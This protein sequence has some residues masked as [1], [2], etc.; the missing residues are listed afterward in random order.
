MRRKTPLNV[1]PGWSH[2]LPMP[3]PGV[4]VSVTLDDAIGQ[5]SRLPTPPRVFFWTELEHRCPEG[6]GHL[7]S[8]RPGVPPEA[9]EAELGAWS[10]QYPEAWLA[11]DLRVG[12][13]PPATLTPL[14]ELISTLRRPV[15]IVIDEDE[16]PMLG[17]RWVLP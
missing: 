2:S 3:M 11:V 7:P 12:S 14:E 15:L 16:D 6:W 4:P 17:P 10:R 5:T 8:V 1:G 13:F 9:I